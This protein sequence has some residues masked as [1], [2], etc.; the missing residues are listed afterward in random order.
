MPRS[1]PLVIVL[2]GG[3]GGRLELLTRDRAKPAVPFA[4]T[5]R[6]VDFPMSNCHNAG[7]DDVWIS[8]QFNPISLSDHL[9]SG[10]PWD[11]DRTSGGLLTLQPRLGND[12]RT[13]FQQ[14]TADALWR[15]APLIREFEPDA[16]VV[17]SADAVYSLD[18]GA[19]IE[20]HHEAGADVTMVT[21]R[22]D[23][24]DAG[25]YGV[26]QAGD[27]RI[28][29]YVY[30]PDEPVGDVIANEVFAFR[31]PALLDTLD[32]LAA[33]VGEDGLQDL[34][35]ELLPRL[36]AG[37]KA[38]EYAFGGYWRDVGT[39]PAYWSAHQELLADEPPFDL[40]DPS[41]PILT[42][43]S[44]GHAPSRILAGAEVEASLLAPAC[45]VSGSVSRSV[46]GRGAIIEAG[47]VVS[48]SVILPGAV[49]RAGARVTRAI[50]DDGVSVG[51]G[52]TVG[53]AD[54]DIALVGLR[55]GVA[56]GA[57]VAAGGRFPDD[58]G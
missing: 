58:D 53:A 49:V 48:E 40:D 13:G 20:E 8:Q 33:E 7:L 39:I 12:D 54:G 55:A 18:Y 3:A 43:A 30:K 47:A 38:L 36:V 52:A 21:T 27:G 1:R 24:D 9:S 19:L 34:G 51:H 31:T 42:R 29:E 10:R 2:A 15:Y 5:H 16:I 57:T 22:V 17:V 35:H 25:R 23:P 6:L 14:G 56:E 26:V 4:G 44:G 32:D 45:R 28:R 11:L 46:I 37:G 50:L 41:W